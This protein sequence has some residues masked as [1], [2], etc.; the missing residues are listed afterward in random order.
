[1]ES[2]SGTIKNLLPPQDHII[3]I[4]REHGRVSGRASGD[5]RCDDFRLEDRFNAERARVTFAVIENRYQRDYG[6]ATSGRA[7]PRKRKRR[8]GD[9]PAI[10]SAKDRTPK[11]GHG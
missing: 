9:Q 3:K 7:I 4:T 1:L 6:R 10:H 5:Y 2:V 11:I 8:A